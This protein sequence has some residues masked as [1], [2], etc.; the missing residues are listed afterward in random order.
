MSNIA[1]FPT[2]KPEDRF[3]MADMESASDRLLSVAAQLD[4]ILAELSR[5]GLR[6]AY[7]QLPKTGT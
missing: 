5:E 3:R 4:H 1:V 7:G 2:K 6:P